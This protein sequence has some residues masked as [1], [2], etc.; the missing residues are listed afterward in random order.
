MWPVIRRAS[1]PPTEM[2]K[3]HRPPR[4]L[5][6]A[7]L[8]APHA[9]GRSSTPQLH[10]LDRPLFT[11]WSAAPVHSRCLT[12][13]HRQRWS[14]DS[15]I[16]PPGAWYDLSQCAAQPGRSPVRRQTRVAQAPSMGRD[17]S[18]G[19]VPPHKFILYSVRGAPPATSPAS[20]Y[21]FVPA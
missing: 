6:P 4:T 17:R 5:L 7:V 14:D 13:R 21:P 20:G 11:E 12:D 9:A 8:R 3:D 15:R 2:S 16:P 18:R 19:T 1:V 10:S